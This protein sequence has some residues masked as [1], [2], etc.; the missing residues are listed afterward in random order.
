MLLVMARLDPLQSTAVVSRMFSLISG[1]AI[2]DLEKNYIKSYMP[3]TPFVKCT[4][5]LMVIN[6]QKSLNIGVAQI[7]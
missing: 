7:N 1:V 2:K 4:L 5:R 3:I 6:F